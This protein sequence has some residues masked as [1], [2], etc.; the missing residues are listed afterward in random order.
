MT[1]DGYS[2]TRTYNSLL[3]LTEI[4]TMHQPVYNFWVTDMDMQYNF[5]AGQNNGR[6]VSATDAVTGETV[7]YQ[8]DTVNRLSNAAGAGWSLSFGYDQYGNMTSEVPTGSAPGLPNFSS[9]YDVNNHQIGATY[10]GDG[11]PTSSLLS[12]AW[13]GENRALH[14]NTGYW[15]Y[16]PSGKRVKQAGL[17]CNTQGS[18]S[19]EIYFY[20]LN[21]R[22]LATFN[23]S[24]TNGQLQ[25]WLKNRNLYFGGKMIRS[26]NGSVYNG[27]PPWVTVVTDRL[28]SVRANSNGETFSYFPYGTERTTSPSDNRE[29]F[30]TYFRDS[31]GIDYA[32]QRYYQSG[33]GRFLTADPYRSGSG[34]GYPPDPGSWN[35]YAY[36]GADPVNFFDP[37][38][39]K[40]VCT[41]PIDDQTCHD[42]SDGPGPPQQEPIKKEPVKQHDPPKSGSA[43]GGGYGEVYTNAVFSALQALQ[44]P[45]C[46][47]LFN[48]DP[49]AKNH[50][51]PSEVLGD[52]VFGGS[53]VG[54]TVPEGTYFGTVNVAR[55]SLDE[56]AITQPVSGVAVGNGT[57]KALY[58]NILLQ[59]NPLSDYYYGNQSASDLALL[60][61]HELGHVYNIVN[62]LGG[63]SIV[64]D[65]NP[66][67]S[68][69]YDKEALNDTTLQAC[70]PK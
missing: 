50:Y 34:S 24:I 8:Y 45:A 54:G 7:Q 47:A 2:E 70:H 4:R 69:N 58:A 21:G 6:I 42:E 33:T 9:N 57:V 3:Q 44:D 16:D 32:D 14:L 35:R 5:A 60:L 18:C 53:L 25:Y 36:V 62:G 63:S 59:G 28:G 67:G 29:K 30:G 19:N 46:A 66:D 51:D 37:T 38:G 1:W 10:D 64:A 15:S 23:Y 48:T 26:G 20:G 22:K 65:V 55:M 27:T 56:A 31:D 43:G 40:R 12:Y 11:N 13:D 49:G 17:S 52:M 68:I 41:G 39:E 61:I